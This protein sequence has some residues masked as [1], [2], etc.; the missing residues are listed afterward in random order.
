MA[1]FNPMR[2]LVW[3]LIFAFLGVGLLAS[4]LMA[5]PIG[6]QTRNEFERFVLERY[7]TT[8]IPDLAAHYEE[9]G[10]WQGAEQLLLR[11]ERGSAAGAANGNGAAPGQ[12]VRH[13]A[14]LTLLDQA[15]EIVYAIPPDQEGSFNTMGQL[16]IVVHDE[17]VGWLLFRFPPIPDGSPEA[18]FLRRALKAMLLGILVATL[19][20]LL[21]SLILARTLSRPIR[22]LIAATRAMALGAF[23]TQV[24]I[25]TKDELGELGLSFN[26]MSTDLARSLQLRRQM[27]ADI[28]HDL[29]TPLSVILGYTEALNDG[30]FVG[31]PAI[32]AILHDEAQHLSRLIDDLRMLSLADAGEL[33]LQRNMTPPRELL[34][35]S[36]AAH[37]VQA[38]QKGVNLTVVASTDLPRVAVDPERMQQV[39]G[40]LVSNALRYT[41]AGGAIA[42]RGEVV[43]GQVTLYVQDSG[44]GIKPDDLP[45]IFERFYRGD[46]AR[47]NTGESGLGLP[48]AKSL[49]EMHEGV[50]TVA[51][52]VGQGTTFTILLP[53]AS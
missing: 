5:A 43:D 46:R 14:M 29:R 35:R 47:S 10:S 8:L 15:G 2:S 19:M 41:P 23:G 3:K 26:Q 49:V 17:T 32:Y 37:R 7:R 25:R 39:L 31:D 34:E 20:A 42:L 22:A 21:L 51:S 9:H 30:K 16:P 48:I 44:S 27:T 12:P 52:K 50:I 13:F 38:E 1:K 40:N 36:A 24:D 6:W 45:F 28:A 4:L 53:V 11:N 18:E 33:P